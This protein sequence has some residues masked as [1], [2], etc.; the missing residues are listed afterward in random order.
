MSEGSPFSNQ[1]E[2]ELKFI[3]DKFLENYYID[4]ENIKRLELKQNQGFFKRNFS[5]FEKGSMRFL[6]LNWLNTMSISYPFVTLSEYHVPHPP[7][8]LQ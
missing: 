8:F 7:L 4:S 1:S 6:V 2:D 3:D 5:K